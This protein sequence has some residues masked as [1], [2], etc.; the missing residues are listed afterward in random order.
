MA[1]R[2]TVAGWINKDGTKSL[3]RRP[4]SVKIKK[5]YMKK[6]YL[7]RFYLSK[8]HHI[9]LH[10]AFTYHIS[11]LIISPDVTATGGAAAMPRS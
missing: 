6:F 9:M 11:S 4:S 7:K 8:K 3:W 2:S 10:H 5:T 1:N